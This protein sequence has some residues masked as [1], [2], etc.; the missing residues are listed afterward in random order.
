MP[1][2]DLWVSQDLNRKQMENSYYNSLNSIYLQRGGGYQCVFKAY[3]NHKRYCENQGKLTWLPS[4][5]LSYKGDR[6]VTGR[7]MERGSYKAACIKS[8]DFLLRDK[9]NQSK[10]S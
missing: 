10:S 4:L 7:Q 3:G 2:H 5:I 8:N 6:V 1:Q 9:A